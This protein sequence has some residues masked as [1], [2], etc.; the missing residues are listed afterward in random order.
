MVRTLRAVP[1]VLLI[2]LLALALAACG[3]STGAKSEGNSGGGAASTVTKFADGVA[4][5]KIT[6]TADPTGAMKWTQQAYTATAGDVTF[7]V[8]NPSVVIHNFGVEG[9]GVKAYTPNINAN[10]TLNATLKDLKPGEYTIVCTV[11]G[12]REAGMVAKLTVK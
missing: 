10:G 8:K 7:V 6:V 11:A 1:A 9:P 2:G 12:H 3:T 5:Q 4:E